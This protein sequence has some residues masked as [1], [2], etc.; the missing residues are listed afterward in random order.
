MEIGGSWPQYC[1][2]ILVSQ[3]KQTETA[4]LEESRAGNRLT[5][6]LALENGGYL[7]TDPLLGYPSFTKKPKTRVSWM[8]PQ[9]ETDSA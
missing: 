4:K 7:G 3:K 6:L 2:H 9:T 8:D 1:S 5:M